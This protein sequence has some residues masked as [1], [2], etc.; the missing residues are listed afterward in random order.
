MLTHTHVPGTGHILWIDQPGASFKIDVHL[1]TGGIAHVGAL[2][3]RKASSGKSFA[4]NGTFFGSGIYGDTLTLAGAFRKAATPKAKKRFGFAITVFDAP[5]IYEREPLPDD[6]AGLEGAYKGVFK[7]AIGGLGRLLEAGTNV[8]DRATL[9]DPAGQ[10]FQ[11]DIPVRRSRPALGV[12]G[13]GRLMVFVAMEKPNPPYKGM[14]PD[15]VATFMRSHG[16]TDAVFLDGGRS[17]S[18]AVN[19]SVLVKREND[20]TIPCWVIGYG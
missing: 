12:D 9:M 16:V 4:I 3:H 5:T 7:T 2:A 6:L 10:Y 8:A 1:G 18:L 17:T 13:A 14:T 20:S 11:K 15:A 19:G